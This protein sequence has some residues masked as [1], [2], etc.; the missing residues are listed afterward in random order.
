MRLASSLA[1]TPLFS[2]SQKIA[3]AAV[4]L[5]RICQSGTLSP[6]SS[7]LSFENFSLS[8]YFVPD[9]VLETEKSCAWGRRNPSSPGDFSRRGETWSVSLWPGFKDSI[10]RW[11]RQGTGG[12]GTDKTEFVSSDLMAQEGPCP[13]VWLTCLGG[14]RAATLRPVE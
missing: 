1:A 13:S 4:P 2:L 3:A 6:P 9:T 5:G 11:K 12:G 8:T 10:V 7:L 14:R